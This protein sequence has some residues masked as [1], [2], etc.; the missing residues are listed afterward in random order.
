M[1][2]SHDYKPDKE[3]IKKENKRNRDAR[4]KFKTLPKKMIY[5]KNG[6]KLNHEKWFP[7]R[8]IA[9]L[10]RP[11]R[12]I[13]C[14]GVN[15]G[16]TT[17]AKNLI[18]RAYPRF[19]RIMLVHCSPS[20]TEWDDL[21]LSEEDKFTDI[22]DMDEF[23]EE[24]STEK[25]LIILEDVE[26]VGPESKHKNLYMLFRY[27]S[28]HRNTSV[29]LNYQ[30]FVSIPKIAR[31]LANFFT[32]WRMPDGDQMRIIEKKVGLKKNELLEMFE[33][34]CD[35]PRDSLSFDLTL[36]SPAPIRKNLFQV[37]T[38]TECFVNEDF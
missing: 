7:N 27:I 13:L 35:D 18:L 12:A 21:G 29:I 2:I 24:G 37:I 5:M 31:R 26:Y 30:N 3:A 15:S 11:Y 36:K 14:G 38:K 32:I 33:A 20:S 17:T 4:K 28:T 1:N 25:C 9:N 6:D 8:N 16:K 10:P 23:P 34:C 22:P 19:D